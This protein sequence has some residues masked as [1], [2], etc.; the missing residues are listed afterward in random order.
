MPVPTPEDRVGTVI[1]G[2]YRVDRVLGKG[3][4][5]VVL[6]GSHELTGRKVAIK[7]LLPELAKDAD[8]LGRF[9]QEAK[10]AAALNHPNVVD[11]LDMGTEGGEPYLV[12]EL[13]EGESL[14][15]RLEA[16]GQ[17]P[18]GDLLPILLPVI[19]ALAA[20]HDHGIVHRDLKPENI[21]IATDARGRAVPK[22]LDFGIAKLVEGETAVATRTGGILGTPQ[23]MSPE[24]AM[25]EKTVGPESDV[26][27]MGAVLYECLGGRPAFSAPTVAALMM[28]ICSVDPAPL[29][30]WAPSLDPRIARVVHA[31]LTRDREERLATMEALGA[32]LVVAAEASSVELAPAVTELFEAG[33]RDARAFA[34]ETAPPPPPS[35]T[36]PIPPYDHPGLD[37]EEGE[38][39][40]ATG[41]LQVPGGTAEA[42]DEA[43][44]DAFAETRSAPPAARGGPRPWLP[45]GGLALLAALGVGAALW[46]T[47]SDESPPDEGVAGA[48]APPGGAPTDDAPTDDAPIDDAPTDDAT[49]PAAHDAA[50][51]GPPTPPGD[52][53]AEGVDPPPAPSTRRLQS[54]PPGAEVWSGGERLGTTPLDVPVGEGGAVEVE[55]RLAGHRRARVTLTAGESVES[56]TLRP[57]RR[58]VPG[59]SELAP[60]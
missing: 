36:G 57:R 46:L 43:P 39:G 2:R 38:L 35:R 51:E 25:G 8:V 27:S 18:P 19:D 33:R 59:G 15:E 50:D 26:W 45:I 40:P 17:L 47:T 7:V 54:A 14:G 10:A 34:E 23:Y 12:L 22:V 55:L 1:G 3:G 58:R 42:P 53:L 56:V 31:A 52:E 11:T 32:A 48:T 20:A 5:G 4:M 60:R 16:H 37:V 24:Q 9:F 49:G 30:H 6:A 13:L 29:T 28:Q 41:P 21:F 44:V